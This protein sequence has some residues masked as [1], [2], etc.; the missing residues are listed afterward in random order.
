MERLK[1]FKDWEF[2]FIEML[3]VLFF[4]FFVFKL[5]PVKAILLTAGILILSLIGIVIV[6]TFEITKK[7]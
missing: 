2:I 3:T 6:G 4:E 5:E 1:R 7:T